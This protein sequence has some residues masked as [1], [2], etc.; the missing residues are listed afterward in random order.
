[1]QLYFDECCSRRLPGDLKTFFAADYPDLTTAHVLDYYQPGALDS[2]WLEPLK[3][4]KKWIVIT[5]DLGRDPKKE[6]LPIICKQ[7][8]ITHVGFA[9]IIIR[10]T[11][12]KDGFLTAGRV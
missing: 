7:L 2:A 9:P 6:K 11:L 10:E 8:G 3:T 12:I 4:D 5:Q 1:M